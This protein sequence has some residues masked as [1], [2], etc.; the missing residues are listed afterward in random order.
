MKNIAIIY[1]FLIPFVLSSCTPSLF[2]K[3]DNKDYFVEIYGDCEEKNKIRK[4]QDRRNCKAVMALEIAIHVIA[5]EKPTSKKKP[6]QEDV[7][8][9]RRLYLQDISDDLDFYM[10]SF[11][12]VGAN[13]KEMEKM[14]KEEIEKEKKHPA[15][16]ELIRVL[17]EEYKKEK[18]NEK[19]N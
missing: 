8:E 5:K 11:K 7:K 6:T 2:H 13:K 18:R 17:S 15:I 10:D 12:R 9:Y 14:I 16:E 1:I 4:K 3:G 19:N